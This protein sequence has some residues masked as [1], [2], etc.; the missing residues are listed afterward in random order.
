[1]AAADGFGQRRRVDGLDVAVDLAL[2]AIADRVS[3]SGE[4]LR[5]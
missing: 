4:Q 5:E 1:M 3:E 2:A